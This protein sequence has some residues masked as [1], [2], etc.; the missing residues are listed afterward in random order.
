M[1]SPPEN[2]HVDENVLDFRDICVLKNFLEK[3]KRTDGFLQ[4]AEENTV[5]ILHKK[6]ENVITRTIDAQKNNAA[7]DS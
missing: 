6:L 4:H 3:C 7:T 1:Q 5:E 2:P